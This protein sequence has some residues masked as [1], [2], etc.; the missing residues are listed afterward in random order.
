M[1]NPLTSTPSAVTRRRFLGATLAGTAA[2]T[3]RR[4]HGLSKW[5]VSGRLT[6]RPEIESFAQVRSRKFVG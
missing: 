2:T 1:S 6:I 5:I 4:L 3:G